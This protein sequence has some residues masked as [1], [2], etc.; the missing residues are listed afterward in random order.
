[1]YLLPLFI[2]NPFN[3]R[4]NSGFTLLEVLIVTVAIGILSA[5][6]I[7]SWLGFV[8][9]QRTNMAQSAALS[10]LRDAQSQAKR[11]RV[12]WQACFWDDGNQ[13]LAVVQPVASSTNQCRFRNGSP[14]IQGDSKTIVFT[15]NFDQNPSNY[16]R[17]QFKY[18]GSVNGQLGKITFKPRNSD[19][20]KRC[21]IVSTL[22]G[23]MRS[24]KDSGCN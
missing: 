13:V 15:S 12:L 9:R 17:V 4:S 23:A 22:L 7:P 10:I 24:E 6:A 8:D 1:M 5:I 19:Y 21:V 18:D 11:E 20:F 14:L 16:Y 2:K 3:N